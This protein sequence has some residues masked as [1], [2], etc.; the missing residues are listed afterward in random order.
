MMTLGGEGSEGDVDEEEDGPAVGC[1]TSPVVDGCV[2]RTEL[3]SP[4]DA[5]GWNR[6]DASR[7]DPPVPPGQIPLKVPLAAER[8]AG[9]PLAAERTA[10]KLQEHG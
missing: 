6:P 10:G 8:T 5:S 4:A 2:C 7:C 1:E 3:E 9:A